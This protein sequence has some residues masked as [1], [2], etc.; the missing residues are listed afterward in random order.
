VFTP[1]KEIH[2]EKQLF[3]SI[4]GVPKISYSTGVL[5]SQHKAFS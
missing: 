2:P 5:Q 3:Q 4:L 1:W